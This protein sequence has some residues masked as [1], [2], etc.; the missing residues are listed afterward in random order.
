VTSQKLI[1]VR[2]KGPGLRKLESG[3][4]VR[5]SPYK[6]PRV[7]GKDGGQNGLVWISGEPAQE[8][9]VER[10]IRKIDEEAHL[11]GLTERMATWLKEQGGAK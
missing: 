11:G 3:R 4:L 10:A 7:I 8:V 6:I 5:I 1:D 9:I 2:M